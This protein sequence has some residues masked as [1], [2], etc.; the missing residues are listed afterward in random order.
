MSDAQLVRNF[1][2]ESGTMIPKEPQLMNKEEVFFIIKMMLDEIMELGATVADHDEVKYKMIKMITDSKDIKQL[3]DLN[4][5]ELI[6]EQAD[7]F[8]DSYYYSLNAAAKKGVNLSKIFHVV[9]SANMSK[10]DP[11]TG[12]FIKRDDG[13]IIKP[14]GWLPPNIVSEINRQFKEGPFDVY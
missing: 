11:E 12:K 9:H 6:A 2:E 8:V 1:T 4:T 14:D 5:E 3:A 7:A 13:K 10:K